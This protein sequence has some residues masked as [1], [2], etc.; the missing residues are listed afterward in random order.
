VQQLVPYLRASV[1]QYD[2]LAGEMSPLAVHPDDDSARKE[3]LRRPL[4]RGSLIEKLA[5]EGV[6]VTEAPQTFPTLLGVLRTESVRACVS[7]PLIVRGELIGSLNLGMEHRRTLTAEELD[8]LR[9]VAD[10]LAIGIYQAELHER[11]KLYADELEE[12]V[13]RRTAALQASE[14]RFR[15]VFEEAGIG[16]ALA[17]VEGRLMMS[18]PALR[19]MLGYSA[20]ELRGM[21]L[22]EFVHLDDAQADTDSHDPLLSGAHSRHSME[23]PYIR[24]DGQTA[25]CNLI[26]THAQ[27]APRPLVVVM[28][29]E[30]TEQKEAQEALIQAERLAVTGRLAASLAHEINNPLQSVIGCLALA[31]EVLAEGA[32]V[33]QYIQIAVEELDRTA[34]IVDRLRDLHRRSQPED[35]ERADLDALLEQVLALNEKRFRDRGIEVIWQAETDL[36]VLLLIPNRV[37]QVFLN[38]AL[39]AIEAM[40]EGGQLKVTTAR[41]SDPEGARITFADSGTGIPPEELPH[42]FEPFY[43]TKE[44]GLGLGLYVS[45]NIVQEHGGHIEVESQA[46]KGTSATIWLPCEDGAADKRLDESAAGRLS[47]A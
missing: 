3:D 41:T 4:E 14:A 45:R 13:V 32:E 7:V 31:Q 8:V 17:D 42:L 19:E 36:P 25:W 37:Q 27:R 6:C 2:P 40:P 26:V 44:E 47:S 18:N 33:S 1:T 11:L 35:R 30:I 24:K 16:I 38:L 20:N 15:A 23:Q 22:T 21:L 5:Q 34:G 46:G 39:N 43:S 9:E 12:R 10:Q 29:E 28:M